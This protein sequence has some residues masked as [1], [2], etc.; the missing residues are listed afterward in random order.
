MYMHVCVSTCAYMY[1]GYARVQIYPCVIR[2]RPHTHIH[3]HTHT[4]THT[5]PCTR[6]SPLVMEEVELQTRVDDDTVYKIFL[7][8][9]GTR[10]LAGI[11]VCVCVCEEPW[12]LGS[13]GVLAS[14]PAVRAMHIRQHARAHGHKRLR[15]THARTP[16][17]L[18]PRIGAR[19]MQF[20]LHFAHIVGIS[21][22]PRE[23]L[24]VCW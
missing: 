19:S 2:A 18:I 1:I 14:T 10:D 21:V 23:I 16:D 15:C 8:P 7:D 4:H 11:C 12:V 3:T 20:Y 5:H 13:A 9:T 17:D 24:C 22:V 6:H